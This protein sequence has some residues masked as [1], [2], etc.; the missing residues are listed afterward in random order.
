M[1]HGTVIQQYYMISNYFSSGFSLLQKFKSS[2]V[3][4]KEQAEA[5]QDLIKE[6]VLFHPFAEAAYTGPLLDFGRNPF[7]FP[8]VW[9]NRQGVMTP[10]TRASLT[11]DQFLKAIIGGEGMQLLS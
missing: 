10:W 3:V 4:S 2:A 11:G 8:C 9:L 1:S 6:A 5:P 7:M